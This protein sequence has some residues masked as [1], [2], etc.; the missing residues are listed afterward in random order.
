MAIS[1][2]L[3]A[4]MAARVAEAAPP[5]AAPDFNR[6]IRPILSDRCFSCHG[7]D[8]G[9]R[10]AGL[11]LDV[12][13]VATGRLESGQT[14]IVPGMPSAS[15]LLARITSRDPDVVMPPPKVGKPVTAAEAEIL[16]RWI[17]AGAEYRG[18]WAF[19]RVERPRVPDVA[20]PW[21]RTP[22]DRFILERLA[23]GSS[24]MRRPTASRSPAGSRSI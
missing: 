23:R 9:N 2:V 21:A 13:E 5:A 20:S 12:R 22:I 18:H 17:A 6:D 7:P 10:Q 3:A 15:E 16:G 8:A 4:V 19:D 11:R 1:A 24:R 14:A